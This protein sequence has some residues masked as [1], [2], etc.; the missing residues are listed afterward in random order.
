MKKAFDML[1]SRLDVAKKRISDQE[2]IAGE[3]P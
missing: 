2:D 1:T 3:S